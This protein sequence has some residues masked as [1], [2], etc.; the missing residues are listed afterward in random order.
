MLYLM[1]G[2][3]SG[4]DDIKTVHYGTFDTD[5]YF[6]GEV[7]RADQIPAPG[8]GTDYEVIRHF[9]ED[10]K[11]RPKGAPNT[12]YDA[13]IVV[14]DAQCNPVDIKNPG[15]WINVIVDA[16]GGAPDPNFR[17]WT[18]DKGMETI[19]TDGDIKMSQ[20]RSIQPMRG[21]GMGR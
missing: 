18:A 13:V 8:G 14:T 3:K 15:K 16:W 2:I 21:G 6:L 20:A 5:F 4:R 12:D 9:V 1:G 17:P 19:V 11:E 10:I 7:K